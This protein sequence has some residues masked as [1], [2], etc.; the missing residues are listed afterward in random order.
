MIFQSMELRK[1]FK[2]GRFYNQQG[3]IWLQASRSIVI[4]HIPSYSARKSCSQTT[5]YYCR[6]QQFDIL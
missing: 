2:R 4:W 6:L 5:K 3:C 1:D